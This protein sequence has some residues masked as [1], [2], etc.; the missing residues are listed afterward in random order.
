M[1]IYMKPAQTLVGTVNGSSLISQ[2]S[3]EIFHFHQL[4]L[5]Y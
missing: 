2:N 3:G 1:Y 4:S 5:S